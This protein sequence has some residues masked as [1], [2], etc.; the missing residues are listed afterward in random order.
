MLL[1]SLVGDINVS[2]QCALL[3]LSTPCTHLRDSCIGK[4]L[5]CLRLA[6]LAGHPVRLLGRW[7]GKHEVKQATTEDGYAA[8]ALNP[9][10]SPAKRNTQRRKMVVLS[11]P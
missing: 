10:E 7:R 1:L 11:A 3:F 6:Y 2:P 4:D 5:C 9:P 8:H